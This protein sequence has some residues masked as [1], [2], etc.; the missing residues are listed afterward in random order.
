MAEGQKFASDLFE[1]QSSFQLKDFIIRYIKYLPLLFIGIGLSYFLAKV[2]LRYSTKMY[3]ANGSMLVKSEDKAGGGEKDIEAL[4]TSKSRNDLNTE[5]QLMKT[6]YL[7]RRVV[8]R[9]NLNTTIYSKGK[10]KLSLTYKE[11]PFVLRPISAKDSANSVSFEF[12]VLDGGNFKIGN[13]GKVY[14]FG[15]PFKIDETN[16][17]IEL[18]QSLQKDA[19]YTVSYRPIESAAAAAIGAVDVGQIGDFTQLL[20]VTYSSED[21]QLC[22]DAVNAL[23]DE[24]IQM[25]LDE[26]KTV[27]VYTQNFIDERVNSLQDDLKNI[28]NSTRDYKEKNNSI[29]LTAQSTNYL[30]NLEDARKSSV[31]EE[32]KMII[33]QD[34]LNKV[35]AD[36]D[37][38]NVIAYG[39]IEDVNIQNLLLDYNSVY[40]KRQKALQDLETIQGLDAESKAEELK[41]KRKAVIESLQKLVGIYKANIRDYDKVVAENTSKLKDIPGLENELLNYGRNQK[42]V[43][44]LYLFLKKKGEENGIKS[45]ATIANTKVIDRA[46]PN[47]S[48][49]EPVPKT[50]YGLFIFMGILIPVL[51]AY[52][53]EIFNNRIRYRE[54]IQKQTNTPILA[55]VGHNDTDDTLVVKTRSRKVIAE[56]FRM[57]R[58]NLQYTTAG[59]EKFTI[60]VTSTFSGEGKSFISTNVAAAFAI[61]GKKT[62]LLE[63]DLRKPK[64]LEGLKLKKG[65]GISNY[66]VGKVSIDEII[67][68]LPE[69]PNLYVIGS[70]AIPP[71]PAE[72]LLEDSITKLFEKLQADFDIV[73]IDSAPVG[74]V[75]DSMMLGKF[76]DSTLYIV[77]HKYT[78]KKQIRLVDE[79]Y[80]TDK[81]P[82]ISIV[83]NDVRGN[84][85]GYYGYGGYGY[86]YGKKTYGYG[87]GYFEEDQKSIWKNFK[88]KSREFFVFWK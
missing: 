45:A 58:T 57:I 44:E 9:L 60:L 80:V 49:Y 48:P 42:I 79:L 82:R 39:M 53:I 37:M 50:V 14:A 81:L 33:A 83:I 31:T 20:R 62:V 75:T 1:K 64:V 86:G 18:K 73:I 55:E 26:E 29:N 47:G 28:E 66:A 61:S 87:S 24:Y 27:T 72:L 56:Q 59:K 2:K 21:P 69:Y 22:A 84:T 12:T 46:L 52:L 4:F 3:K 36:A 34:I 88:D 74:L 7:M 35:M 8:E 40:F 23:M 41:I 16:L 11:K 43:E 70:G 30:N 65:P 63:F 77:R 68:Q 6:R 15:Q 19:V 25:N 67:R 51:A 54:D 76:A 38:K 10:V 13:S 32:T 85:G 17:Q 71:N 5:M 78:L